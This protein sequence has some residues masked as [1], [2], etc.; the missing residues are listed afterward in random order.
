MVAQAAGGQ[1]VLVGQRAAAGQRG[2]DRS[3]QGLR[4]PAQRVCGVRGDD[5]AAGHQQRRARL[6]QGIGRGLQAPAVGARARQRAGGPVAAELHGLRQQVA[7]Q[8]H[9]HRPRLARARDDEGLAHGF[10]DQV[11]AVDTHRPFGDGPEQLL[12][13]D[14]LAGTAVGVGH[15]RAA[16]EDDDGQRADEGFGDAGHQVGGARPCRDAAHAWLSGELRMAGGH[17]GRNLL[18]A[19]QD[20]ADLG[21][22]VQRVVDAQRVAAGHAEDEAHALGLQHLYDRAPGAHLRHVVLLGGAMICSTS[23]GSA[24]VS[25]AASRRRAMV[26]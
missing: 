7:R 13:R 15:G 20:V 12:L 10:H 1:R 9:Q 4:E 19:H 22:V 23:S 21:R 18:V 11:G 26:E 2:E 17:A 14:L 8:V 16:G 5:A 25:R 3:L 6:Q 24:T